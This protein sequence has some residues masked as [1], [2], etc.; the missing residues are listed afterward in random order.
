MC[1]CVC[2]QVMSVKGIFRRALNVKKQLFLQSDEMTEKEFC[3]GK[4]LL[5]LA[6][7]PEHVFR[8]RSDGR[9]GRV[10]GRPVIVEAHAAAGHVALYRVRDGKNKNKITRTTK[11]KM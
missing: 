10:C 7:G 8:R 5:T 11:K 2:V 4:R 3:R 1:V 6:V 9:I